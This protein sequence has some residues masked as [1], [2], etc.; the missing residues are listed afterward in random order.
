VTFFST[1]HKLSYLD[2]FKAHFKSHFQ[3]IVNIELVCFTMLHLIIT[4]AVINIIL[5][6]ELVILVCTLNMAAG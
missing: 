1:V 6:L 4:I 2:V 3:L 5:V